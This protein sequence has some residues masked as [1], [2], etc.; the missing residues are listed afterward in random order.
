MFYPRSA[1]ADETFLTDTSS[2][3]F[4][5][6]VATKARAKAFKWD[7]V[8]LGPAVWGAGCAQFNGRFFIWMRGTDAGLDLVKEEAERSFGPLPSVRQIPK[9][10]FLA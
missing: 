7:W 8:G 10:A 5:Q 4:L 6:D 2:L 3:S 1:R 9:A